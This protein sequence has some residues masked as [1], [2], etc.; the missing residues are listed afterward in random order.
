MS[1]CPNCGKEV[2]EGDKVCRYCGFD[3][4]N[5]KAELS[6]VM[7]EKSTVL[8]MEAANSLGVTR[9]ELK[10]EVQR[11]LSGRYG[12]WVP[13]IIGCGIVLVVLIFLMILVMGNFGAENDF[14]SDYSGYSY[15]EYDRSNSGSNLFI[16]GLLSLILFAIILLFSSQI[17]PVLQW[18]G[19]FTL[20]G[21]K[22]DGIK[23]FK[24]FVKSQKNRVIKANLLI[25]L[26]TFLW[27]LLFVIPGIIKKASYAM[28]NYLLE[29]RPELSAKEAIALSRQIMKG[30]KLEY[31][32][33]QASFYFW[34]FLYGMTYG[35]A[36]FYVVPYY[37]VTTMAF[38][39]VLYQ[40]FEAEQAEE[41][42]F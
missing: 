34:F 2:S 3:L 27:S 11:K 20:R 35:L 17:E 21:Q 13:T 15:V 7:K 5:S 28:T 18:S 4:T 29:K 36:G 38:L 31:L 30:Y 39:E 40:K 41:W 22:A 12:E 14:Y 6:P 8:Q 9:A 16:G 19:I 32:F 33:L 10:Q 24:Y 23:I 26:Y 1:N 25:T 42:D 37:S